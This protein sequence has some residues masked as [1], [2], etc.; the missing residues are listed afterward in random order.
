MPGRIGHS[1]LVQIHPVQ[2]ISVADITPYLPFHLPLHIERYFHKK[3]FCLN[4]SSAKIFIKLP[5][6]AFVRGE[7]ICIY[8]E[9]SN[10]HPKNPIKNSIVGLVMVVRFRCKDNEKFK[11]TTLSYFT[12]PLIP[13]CSIIEFQHC[14]KI[15]SNAFPTY[16]H[17]DALINSSYHL[18]IMISECTPIEIPVIIGTEISAR[19]ID[20]QNHQPSFLTDHIKI[21][22]FPSPLLQQTFPP[23]STAPQLLPTESRSY[24]SSLPTPPS[25]LPIFPS[26]FDPNFEK[27]LN[28]PYF[29]PFCSPFP[30]CHPNLNHH[31]QATFFPEELP[32]T[33]TRYKGQSV[34][35][36]EE[37]E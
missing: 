1:E 13:Q 11:N 10:E 25:S 35:R 36:I 12:L 24:A 16:S 27:H 17:P 2:V 7:T 9:I 6:T 19:F 23:L 15:P 30:L 31:S 34:L 14:L 20:A 21:R 32:A 18:S 22:P 29:V 28:E 5:K 26:Y 33:R 37:I 3:F 8:G 4:K